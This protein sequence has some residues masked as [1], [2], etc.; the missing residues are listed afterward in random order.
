MEFLFQFVGRLALFAALWIFLI[1]PPTVAVFLYQLVVRRSFR[2]AGRISRQ[3]ARGIMEKTA[4]SQT[5]S[6]PPVGDAVWFFYSGAG[7]CR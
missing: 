7:S 4:I 2:E 3:V 6:R 1:V 5:S